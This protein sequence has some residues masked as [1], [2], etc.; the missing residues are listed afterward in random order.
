MTFN[1]IFYFAQMSQKSG[2]HKVDAGDEEHPVST[3]KT[4]TIKIFCFIV[5]PITRFSIYRQHHR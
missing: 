3:N 2:T 5:I 4:A 1:H